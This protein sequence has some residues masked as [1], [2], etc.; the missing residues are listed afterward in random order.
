MLRRQ[1]SSCEKPKVLSISFSLS[2]SLSLSLPP[3]PSLLLLAVCPQL[4]RML[5]PHH[6]RLPSVR[7]RRRGLCSSARVQHRSKYVQPGLP[8]SKAGSHKQRVCIQDERARVLLFFGHHSGSGPFKHGC[9]HHPPT[10]GPRPP[11]TRHQQRQRHRVAQAAAPRRRSAKDRLQAWR[12][13]ST[14]FSP[15][16]GQ[17]R[18]R[19]FNF[20]SGQGSG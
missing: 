19:R 9:A 7:V 16:S 12:E 5:P 20:K 14:T 4:T 2:P 10:H 13:D 1:S 8:R 18:S 15:S 17:G 6:H 11:F 3:S